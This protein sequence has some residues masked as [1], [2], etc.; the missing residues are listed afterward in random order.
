[1]VS[2]ENSGQVD[3]SLI[4][5]GLSQLPD[6]RFGHVRGVFDS[7][8]AQESISEVSSRN[9]TRQCALRHILRHL[10]PISAP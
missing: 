3:L 9:G 1:M 7:I 5:F 2:M 4:Y 8:F 6:V 10:F